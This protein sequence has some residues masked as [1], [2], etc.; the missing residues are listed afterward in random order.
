MKKKRKYID[1]VKKRLAVS[2]SWVLA[3][4]V[5]LAYSLEHVQTERNGKSNFGVVDC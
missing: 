3:V 2:G 1:L 4:F 5:V